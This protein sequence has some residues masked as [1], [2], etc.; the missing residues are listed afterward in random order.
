MNK[1]G[2]KGH[3]GQ[4]G[5]CFDWYIGC[6]VIDI[7][8]VFRTRFFT[9]A[10]NCGNIAFDNNVVNIGT[11]SSLLVIGEWRTTLIDLFDQHIRACLKSIVILE[12][13]RS[14]ILTKWAFVPVKH[15]LSAY[16]GHLFLNWS[17]TSSDPQLTFP[18]I[19]VESQ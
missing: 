15:A 11:C 19:S 14:V 17:G 7:A 5:W 16:T 4:H 1:Y 13:Q 6:D 9:Y 3:Y 18:M 10:V 2:N 12:Y 8:K